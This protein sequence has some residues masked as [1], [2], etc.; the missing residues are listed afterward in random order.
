LNLITRRGVRRFAKR[1]LQDDFFVNRP[2]DMMGA[3]V[4]ISNKQESILEVPNQVLQRQVEDEY[5]S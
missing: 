1:S 3:I 4:E 5:E 2:A